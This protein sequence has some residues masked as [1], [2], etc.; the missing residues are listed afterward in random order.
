MRMNISYDSEIH[1][2]Y[3]PKFSSFMSE[4][5]DVSRISIDQVDRIN[6][7]N[8]PLFDGQS[9]EEIQ[10]YSDYHQMADTEQ[11]SVERHG[12]FSNS[13]IDN[14]MMLPIQSESP[15][16]RLDLQ[17]KRNEDMPSIDNTHH[18]STTMPSVN[19]SFK[20]KSSK[21]DGLSFLHNS[22]KYDL[23]KELIKSKNEQNTFDTFNEKCR[24]PEETDRNYHLNS[25]T[26]SQSRNLSIFDNKLT[27]LGNSYA[28]R[29]YTK[30][31]N[32]M[33]KRYDLNQDKISEYSARTPSCTS[34]KKE[35]ISQSLSN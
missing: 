30:N 3:S 13:P 8:D 6:A 28:K 35:K 10:I 32:N 17:F 16:V 11:M 31:F 23:S 2:I 27:D 7:K 22:R 21:P 24:I 18:M 4:D 1:N 12:L 33:N 5:S 15:R 20:N 9:I 14:R 29:Y 19:F 26:P 25:S 34:S